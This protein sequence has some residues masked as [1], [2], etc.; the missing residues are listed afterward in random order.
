[1]RLNEVIQDSRFNK[2]IYY[3]NALNKNKNGN[4]R[5]SEAKTDPRKNTQN[6]TKRMT[7]FIHRWA[8]TQSDTHTQTREWVAGGQWGRGRFIEQVHTQKGSQAGRER[9]VQNKTGSGD[10]MALAQKVTQNLTVLTA[11][12]SVS[13]FLSS[14]SFFLTSYTVY[15]GES[16][17]FPEQWSHALKAERRWRMFLAA[18]SMLAR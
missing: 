17:T 13:F 12:P 11:N 10:K 2:E 7:D 18:G 5:H 1:M 14:S 6:K 9:E 3:K 15:S 8:R 4:K 16:N